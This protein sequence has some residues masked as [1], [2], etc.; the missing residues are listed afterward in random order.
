MENGPIVVEVS[1]DGTTWTQ[2]GDKI[3]R[4]GL[5]RMWKKYVRSYN[6]T[7]EVYA[8]VAQHEGGSTSSSGPKV[9]DIYIANQ[10]E[11]SLAL[12]QQL[13]EEL[14]GIADV[15]TAT[16]A[17]AGIYSINGIRQ[18]GLKA[19]LNIVVEADGTVKKIIRK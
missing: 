12:L 1:T 6:G 18:N 13:K 9:F 16:R 2:V 17:A 11:K 19:G 10:G 15:K 14:T 7:D 8:R 4:T 3:D 5:S